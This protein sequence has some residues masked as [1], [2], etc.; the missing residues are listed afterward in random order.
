MRKK[1][2]KYLT[3]LSTIIC[4]T[5]TITVTLVFYSK[6]LNSVITN[7]KDTGTSIAGIIN[8]SNNDSYLQGIK[9][10]NLRI[11][12]IDKN[13][14]VL[15][16]TDND[17]STLENH[18]DRIEFQN[19]LKHGY[20][21][22]QRFSQTVEKNL[23]YY[24][25]K[26]ENGNIL[27][28][29]KPLDNM[30]TYIF[31]ALPFLLLLI[32]I[33]A[34]ISNSISK[35]LTKKVIEPIN[36]TS[37]ELDGVLTDEFAEMEFEDLSSYEE[38]LPFIRK[39]KYLNKEIRNYAKEIKAQ[40]YTLSTITTNMQEGFILLD[41]QQHIVSINDSAK[42]S[43]GTIS[44]ADYIG[45]PFIKFCRNSVILEAIS[46]AFNTKNK[47]YLDINNNEFYFKY[48][49]NPV[50]NETKDI[51]G[52][53]ILII[54]TT[55]EM[56]NAIMRRDFASNVSHE[57]KTPLTSINGF[58]EML[59]NNMITDNDELAKTYKRIRNESSRMITLINDIM[60][61]SQIESNSSIETEEINLEDTINEV[62]TS[63]SHIANDKQV[64]FITSTSP[65]IINANNSMI[66]ELIFNLA[67]NAIK[68]NK[69]NGTVTIELSSDE[70]YCILRISDTGIGIES[71]HLNRIFE[72]F[73]RIDKSRSKQ[74]GGTGL[75]LSIV[76]H[77]VENHNGKINIS[78]T[79]GKGTIITVL[80]PLTKA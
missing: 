68:Y 10:G 65:V 46:K 21:E 28:I 56:T 60:R 30:L 40:R 66:Y 73:Y 62:I 7:T 24:A 12:L 76:K 20:G 4:V 31:K 38:F 5:I 48:I 52:I 36:N 3:V 33:F 39:I 44:S 57:L 67:E 34:I 75:G 6:Y 77:I 23:Y 54:N 47:I 17:Y 55:D 32:F 74:T 8:N 19:A 69:P 29:S 16:D 72:R 26:L 45:Q 51:N 71:K 70:K 58:A 63:L 18:S 27:R 14:I 11:S 53:F 61:L 15:Y 50:L 41:N 9:T 79:P 25:I 35:I 64:K 43:A 1:F 80:L 37:R 78:S 2:L 59:E 49:I 22:S 42:K 13:G